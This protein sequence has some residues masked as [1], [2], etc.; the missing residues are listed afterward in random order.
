MKFETKAEEAI[1]MQEMIIQTKRD[2]LAEL[3]Q[4]KKTKH[5][6]L[7]NKQNELEQEKKENESKTR[8]SENDYANKHRRF[9]AKMIEISELEIEITKLEE[10]LPRP[11]D[12]DYNMLL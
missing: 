5:Q 6:L 4:A 8:I 12:D 10:S 3:A 2:E 9:E 1:A 11:L 7:K